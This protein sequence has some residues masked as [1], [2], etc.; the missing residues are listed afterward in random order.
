[1]RQ[2]SKLF[3]NSLLF[4]YAKSAVLFL[5]IV[6]I[7]YFHT[8]KQEYYYNHVGKDGHLRII[9]AED[10]ASFVALMDKFSIHSYI[11]TTWK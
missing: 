3:F 10:D 1:L 7:A 2:K 8:H 11:L 4:V 9:T 5:V 6:N